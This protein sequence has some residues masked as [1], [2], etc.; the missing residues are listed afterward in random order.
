M[1][2]DIDNTI[3]E[4]GDAV[5]EANYLPR[6]GGYGIIRGDNGRIAV[7]ETPIGIYLPGGGID[8]GESAEDAVIR[9]TREESGLAVRTLE[10][11][12][13]ANELVYTAE[14]IYFR[15]QCTFF[16]CQ[17]TDAAAVPIAEP[18]HELLWI[19][20]GDALERLSHGSQRWAVNLAYG[21]APKA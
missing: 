2:N 18:D 6:P 7:V 13:V 4:F 3:P 15:K 19:S 17:V 1:I 11:I 21:G 14:G 8:P 16:T 20:P 10:M 12:G 5:P 9:E